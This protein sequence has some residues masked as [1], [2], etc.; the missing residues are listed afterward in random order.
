MIQAP[1]RARLF[2]IQSMP[3]TPE[4]IRHAAVEASASL[5]H[6]NIARADLICQ[7]VLAQSVRPAEILFI[8]AQVAMAIGEHA[9]ARLRFQ[10]L[11]KL[12]PTN[13]RVATALADTMRLE[14]QAE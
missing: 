9:T 4:Q 2:R 8:N 7:S 13:P 1:N 6:G 11:L 10:E 14:K 5:S 3:I 12:N